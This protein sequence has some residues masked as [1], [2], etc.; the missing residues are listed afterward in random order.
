MFFLFESPLKIYE[1][2]EK[3]KLQ[4]LNPVVFHLHNFMDSVEKLVQGNFI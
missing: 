1:G 3:K 2:F 4:E